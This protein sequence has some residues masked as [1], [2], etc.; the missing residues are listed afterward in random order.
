MLEDKMEKISWKGEGKDSEI[1][2]K[3]YRGSNPEGSTF[4]PWV[5]QKGTQREWREKIISKS[6]KIF[7][8]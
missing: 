4:D 2:N 5:F 7:Q 6:K 3:K 8:S 1:E